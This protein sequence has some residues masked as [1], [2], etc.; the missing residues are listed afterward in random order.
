MGSLPPLMTVTMQKE[1]S[2]KGSRELRLLVTSLS[3][4][5]KWLLI[6]LRS[7]HRTFIIH[8]IM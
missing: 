4:L 2:P 3:C 1:T 6:I 8:Y 7:I 5:T